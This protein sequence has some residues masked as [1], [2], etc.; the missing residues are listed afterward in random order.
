AADVRRA[1]VRDIRRAAQMQ[2]GRDACAD[3]PIARP[4]HAGSRLLRRVHHPLDVSRDYVESGGKTKP[5][6]SGIKKSCS[7]TVRNTVASRCL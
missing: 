3:R 1:P 4:R 6:I 5:H 7:Y 2:K